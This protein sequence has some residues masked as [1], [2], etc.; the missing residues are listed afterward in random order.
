MLGSFQGAMSTIQFQAEWKS[1]WRMVLS[2]TAMHA[3]TTKDDSAF[4]KAM[5]AKAD[6]DS[7]PAVPLPAAIG[8]YAA[9]F[10]AAQIGVSVLARWVG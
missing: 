6:V 9:T 1:Y 8:F 10:S 5:L 4:N 3:L 7:A 2:E